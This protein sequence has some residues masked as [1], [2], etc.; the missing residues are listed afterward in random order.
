MKIGKI[1]SLLAIA[2]VVMSCNKNV[3]QNKELKTAID[4]VSYAVGVNSPEMLTSSFGEEFDIDLFYQGYKDAID[5]TGT[6]IDKTLIQGVIQTYMQKRQ[7]AEREKQMAEA[8]KKAEEQFG[9][10]K[11]AGEKLMAENIS[12]EGVQTT[13]SGLQ[14][15]VLKAGEGDKPTA[16]DRVKVHYHGTLFDGTVFDSSVDRGEPATFGVGQVIPG[17]IEG[18]QLMSVGAKYKFFVPQELAYGHQQRGQHIKPFT[19][20]IFEVELLEIVK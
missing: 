1:L 18:L 6:K 7:M 17:W 19:P 15:I 8:S 12:K 13:E 2:L 5:S 10:N 11:A 4:S 20:L 14:Y 16:T 9:E 3:A